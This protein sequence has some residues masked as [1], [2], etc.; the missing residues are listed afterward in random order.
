MYDPESSFQMYL[1]MKNHVKGLV[2]DGRHNVRRKKD[3]ARYTNYRVMRI[4]GLTH[5]R[6][7]EEADRRGFVTPLTKLQDEASLPRS[8]LHRR[9]NF[10]HTLNYKVYWGPPSVMEE[11]NEYEGRGGPPW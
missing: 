1:T 3:I 4:A 2:S 8:A 9:F 5:D 7:K 6:P 11:P 10:P